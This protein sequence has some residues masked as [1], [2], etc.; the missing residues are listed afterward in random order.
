MISV[1][2]MGITVVAGVEE[3]V[4]LQFSYQF[5]GYSTF[6]IEHPARLGRLRRQT[7]RGSAE[8]VFPADG[9]S[10]EGSFALTD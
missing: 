4:N 1:E 8:C 2:S 10:C 6:F 9:C 7:A 5:V 3:D